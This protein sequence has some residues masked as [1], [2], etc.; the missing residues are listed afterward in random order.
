VNKTVPVVL[1]AGVECAE[2]KENAFNAW[3]NSTFPQIM[4]K[5][6]GVTRVERFERIGEN[7]A[8]PKFISMVQFD[9]ESYLNAMG[10]VDASKEIARL[11]IGKATEWGTKVRWVVHYR[12]IFPPNS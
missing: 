3:Y 5:V 12:K 11:F 6:P 8:H 10:Q 2:G 7:S 1:M 9:N 4:M